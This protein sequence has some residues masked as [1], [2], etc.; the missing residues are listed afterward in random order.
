MTVELLHYTPLEIAV[1]AIRTCYDSKGDNLG[2]KDI[3]LLRSI[4]DSGH[5]STIE[6]L[7]YNFYID[8]ISRACLQEL[9]RHRI[10]SYSVRSTRYTLRELMKEELGTFITDYTKAEKYLVFTGN[11]EIDIASAYAL[12]ALKKQLLQGTKNDIAKYI[13]PE[14]YKTSL[15]WT[16]NARSLRNFLNLRLSPR[17]L[18]EIRELASKVLLALPNEHKILFEDIKEEYGV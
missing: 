14:S 1:K 2:E 16:I 5:T 6:H 4:I 18:K 10:A 11:K 12:E 9:A 8:G 3:K 17:A 15:V 7:S 13:L